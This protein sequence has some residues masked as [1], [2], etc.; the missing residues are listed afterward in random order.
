MSV[1]EHPVF[2]M[3]SFFIQQI[4]IISKAKG[5]LS[6]RILDTIKDVEFNY[7]VKLSVQAPKVAVNVS[8]SLAKLQENV[9]MEHN[10]TYFM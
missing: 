7:T 9:F 8:T 3:T 6:D 4:M 1:I 10:L 2:F 5:Y